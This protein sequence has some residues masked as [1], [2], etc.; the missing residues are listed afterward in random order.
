MSAPRSR[1]LV[2]DGCPDVRDSLALLLTSWGHDVRTAQ[3]GA[4]ALEA[5]RSF[6]PDAVVLEIRLRD[7][8]GV[9]RPEQNGVPTA[10]V[11][12]QGDF[13]IRTAINVVEHRTRC[14]FAGEV[15]Q[16][17]NIDGPFERGATRE[18]CVP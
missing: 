5:F 3:D 1:V 15:T 7:M 6:L 10:A 13:T 11:V 14:P 17:V 2:V 16:I 12:A 4:S 9:A 8:D 18:E